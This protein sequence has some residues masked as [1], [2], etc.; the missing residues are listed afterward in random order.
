MHSA[1]IRVPT[2]NVSAIELTV[3][4]KVAVSRHS[5]DECLNRAAERHRGIISVSDEPLASCDFV[6]DSHSA[7]ID[8][9][10]SAVVH[11][12]LVKILIWFDNE[13]G[14]A[15]RLIDSALHLQ[16]MSKLGDVT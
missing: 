11:D 14:Y 13:W 5:L 9:P 2:T 4:T 10:Q 16:H 8:I 15:N 1:S 3:Q 7:V 6:H 12:H